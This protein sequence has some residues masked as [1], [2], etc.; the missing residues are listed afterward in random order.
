MVKT[1]VGYAKILENT[2]HV[3]SNLYTGMGMG[4]V[5]TV[6]DKRLVFSSINLCWMDLG[7][8]LQSTT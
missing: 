3:F 7:F 5:G 6:A 2:A 1:M 8:C 4:H